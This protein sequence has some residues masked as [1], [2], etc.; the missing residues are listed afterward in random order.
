MKPSDIAPNLR[1][2]LTF[3]A[4]EKRGFPNRGVGLVKHVEPT[5]YW[6]ELVMAIHGVRRFRAEELEPIPVARAEALLGHARETAKGLRKA[7]KDLE[8]I[9]EDTISRV[10]AILARIRDIASMSVIL[11]DAYGVVEG[12]P[13][14]VESPMEDIQP[15]RR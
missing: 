1:V 9:N 4:A 8:S 14:R 3:E 7:M 5:S 13:E 11:K 2:R 6:V 10:P 12:E 15:I